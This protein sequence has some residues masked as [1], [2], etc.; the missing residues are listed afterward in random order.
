MAL[1]SWE[2]PESR[3]S[4]VV[5]TD[6]YA[7]NFERELSSF[8]VGRCDEY[9]DHRGGAYKEMYEKEVPEKLQVIIEDL[10]EDRINDPGDDGIMRAPMDLAP[11]P[12]FENIGDGKILPLKA[13]KKPKHPAYNSVAIFLSRKPTE[14]E[15]A[16]LI[17]RTRKFVE[18]PPVTK[19]EQRPKI[20][21]IRLVE[22]RMEIVSRVVLTVGKST[23]ED[24]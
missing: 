9:G 5:D 17:L 7:G 6:S 21:V 23:K 15:F 8:V 24:E 20:L 18:L 1:W 16:F 3:W 11:T 4:F 10:T 13:G 14:D 12:G 2:N 22:E 19:W